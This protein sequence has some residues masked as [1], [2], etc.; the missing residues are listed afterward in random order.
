MIEIQCTQ[1]KAFIARYKGSGEL[2]L[3]FL[4][5]VIKPNSLADLKSSSKSD[6]PLLICHECGRKLGKPAENKTG[7][8]AYK[9]IKTAF[10][11]KGIIKAMTPNPHTSWK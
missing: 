1:C 7:R 9:M 4:D 3:L 8:V 10:R 2:D 5:S 11:K 6:L